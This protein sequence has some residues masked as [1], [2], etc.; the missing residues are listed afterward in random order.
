MRLQF[1][2]ERN[3]YCF[4]LRVVFAGHEMKR[5][6]RLGLF[7]PLNDPRLSAGKNEI[8]GLWNTNAGKIECIIVVKFSNARQMAPGYSPARSMSNETSPL[9]AK[10]AASYIRDLGLLESKPSFCSTRK[11]LSWPGSPT[12][13]AP[14]LAT[15][16]ANSPAALSCAPSCAPSCISQ[17][18]GSMGAHG[19]RC[20]G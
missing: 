19:F 13:Q 20:S 12:P 3:L 2:C 1:G 4:S 5:L 11:A 17:G 16:H 7:S 14:Q 6:H 18:G 10:W 15:A 9:S 8:T